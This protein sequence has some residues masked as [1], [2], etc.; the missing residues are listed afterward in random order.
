ML[1]VGIDPGVTTGFAIWSET[2]KRLTDVTS[3]GCIEAMTRCELMHRSG[4]L[5]RIVLEDARMSSRRDPNRARAQGAGSVKRDCSLWGEWAELHQVPLL[6][7]RATKGMT[8]WDAATFQRITGWQGRTNSHGR[9]AAV[10]VFR[11]AA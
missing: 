7:I 2:D 10:L 3:L 6:S 1:I 9:D 11:G 5:K 8:K 4:A